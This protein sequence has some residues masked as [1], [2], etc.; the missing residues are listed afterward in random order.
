[1]LTDGLTQLTKVLSNV[2]TH[3]LIHQL[4]HQLTH[5]LTQLSNLLSHDC[6]FLCTSLYIRPGVQWVV[7]ILFSLIESELQAST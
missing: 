3:Q 5:V 7:P 6:A 2:L 1:M 4:T